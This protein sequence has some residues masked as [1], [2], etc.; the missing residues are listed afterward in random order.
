VRNA[1][2]TLQMKTKILILFLLT[3]FF[4]KADT[5]STWNVFYNNKLIKQFNANPSK[6][7]IEIKL[8][9][10]KAGD[11]LAI[12]YGDDMPC[13]DCEYELKIITDTK[14]EVLK[15]KTKNK[16]QLMKIDLKEI[17][18]DFKSWSQQKFYLV[19]FTEI[20]RKGKRDS[21]QRLFEIYV[22]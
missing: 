19:Y 13:S 18:E 9:K 22:E 1:C 10:Y 3:S 2:K 20:N 11:Y 12:K 6:K 14:S 8:S 5:I 17:I 7:K 21:G 16:Y 15:M 4:A